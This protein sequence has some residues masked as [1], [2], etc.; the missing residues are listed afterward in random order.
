MRRYGLNCPVAR[1]LDAIGER[2]SVL[3]LRDL[4]LNSSR[5]F[6]DFEAGMPALTPSVLSARLKDLESRGIIA[7]ELYVNH[8]PRLKYFL[9]EK[10]R[11]LGPVLM[12]LKTWGEK[13]PE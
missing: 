5:R 2:W 13:Y 1:C 11:D 3:I 6:Q 7:S 12:A 9:T 8:P 10:G 4:F